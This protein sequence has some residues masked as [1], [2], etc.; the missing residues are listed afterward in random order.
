MVALISSVQMHF[1]RNTGTL[2][3]LRVWALHV[4]VYDVLELIFL[5]IGRNLGHVSSLI[6]HLNV[7]KRSLA[8]KL[9]KV[10]IFCSFIRIC[11]IRVLGG[12]LCDV[13]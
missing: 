5:E 8:I 3:L 11:S 2:K 1:L 12:I 4:M 7:L 9:R 6:C 10:S 13:S